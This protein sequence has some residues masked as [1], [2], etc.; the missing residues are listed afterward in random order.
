MRC[1]P[2]WGVFLVLMGTGLMVTEVPPRFED[3]FV[4]E[5]GKRSSMT[6]PT[7]GPA[8][9]LRE[10]PYRG[11]VGCGAGA[12]DVP[13]N[14]MRGLAPSARADTGGADDEDRDCRRRFVA[15]TIPGHFLGWF[16]L[17]AATRSA[18]SGHRPGTVFTPAAEWRCPLGRRTRRR[19][20]DCGVGGCRR[21]CR[22]WNV[23]LVRFGR[24]RASRS[25]CAVVR[26]SGF[27]ARTA[28]A[29]PPRFACCVACC[30][31]AAVDSGW[32]GVDVRRAAAKARMHIGYMS[33]KFSLYGNLTVAQ[34]LRFFA[35]AYGLQG[36]PKAGTHDMG[37]PDVWTRSGG[38]TNQ[39]FL[40]PRVQAA[41]GVGVCADARACHF[42]SG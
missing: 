5:L 16:R 39:R 37:Q 11:E 14:E 35:R 26:S 33:Q 4:E 17:E 30:L 13:G 41:A 3:A 29:R 23:G 27:W 15:T 2:T 9:S 34:N 18:P 24:S 7:F 31:P 38:R 19:G 8:D 25:R 12:S 40:A 36:R 21:V 42:I 20:Q 1:K 22:G 10:K 28:R 32:P 6:G